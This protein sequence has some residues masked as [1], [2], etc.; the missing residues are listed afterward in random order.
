MYA[1]ISPFSKTFDDVWLI[2]SIPSFL[3][4]NIKVGQIAEFPIKNK[5]E[6]WVILDIKDSIR[7]DFDESKLKPLISLKN[8]NLFISNYRSELLI[9]ISQYYIT[10]IHN[11]LNLFLPRNLREKIFKNKVKNESLNDYYY[12]YNYSSL[13]TTNQSATYNNILNSN[14]DN[15][16]LY[17]LTWS[18]KT[19][20]YIKLIKDTLDKGKQSLFLIPE[21]ILTNQLAEKIIN[22][23]W[24]KVLIINSTISEATKTKYWIDINKSCAKII[25]WTRSAIFYPYN[26]LWLIIIDEEHDKSYLS[27]SAPRYNTIEVAEKITEINW[28]KL[29]LWSWT[30]SVVSMYKWITKKYEIISLLEVYKKKS[31]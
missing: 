24:K 9:W 21:I 19:E 10:A 15:I 12:S 3:L 7:I 25:I 14:N 1:I 17:W 20:I 6:I 4:D 2:Y 5:T 18:W 23:F 11:S 13:L 30:P 31:L 8:E 16:L 29:I 22:I 26:N 28:N 27:D